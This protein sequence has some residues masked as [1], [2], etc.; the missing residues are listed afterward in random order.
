MA[1]FGAPPQRIKMR[2]GERPALAVQI[3]R[4]AGEFSLAR[5]ASKSK[6]RK[7]RCPSDPELA[8]RAPAA[9]GA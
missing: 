6:D 3:P 2:R 4:R 8:T 1:K 9:S 7:S 5:A